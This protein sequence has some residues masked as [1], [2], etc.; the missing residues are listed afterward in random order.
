MRQTD[1][2]VVVGRGGIVAPAV[3]AFDVARGQAGLDTGDAVGAIEQAAE[4]E[5]A[6]RRAA[7]AFALIGEEPGAAERAVEAAVVEAGK[8]R[9]SRPSL[10]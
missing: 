8:R 3:V 9:A 10:P 7:V 5:A 2:L 6:D 4:R 1:R